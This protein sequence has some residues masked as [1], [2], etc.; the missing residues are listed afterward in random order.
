[1]RSFVKTSSKRRQLPNCEPTEW[2]LIGGGHF[3]GAAAKAMRRILINH[4]RD[5]GRLKRGGG[6]LRVGLTAIELVAEDGSAEL[7][8]FDEA[9]EQLERQDARMARIV[10][11]RFF[12]GRSIQETAAALELSTSTVK[13]E[14]ALA[15]AWLYEALEEGMG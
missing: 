11:L 4:A 1:M 10:R 5:R 13:R 8:A 3:F 2:H 7:L 9:L 15:R 6:R 12:A 14:W